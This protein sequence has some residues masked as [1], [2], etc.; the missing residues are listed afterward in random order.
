MDLTVGQRFYVQAAAI[1]NYLLPV[2]VRS[3]KST[4][5]DIDDGYSNAEELEL[6]LRK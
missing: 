6:P 5:T 2:F 1:G 4:K 3:K